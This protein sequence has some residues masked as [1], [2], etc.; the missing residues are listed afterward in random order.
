[1][2]GADVGRV[3]WTRLYWRVQKD[4]PYA[5]RPTSPTRLTAAP[6]LSRRLRRPDHKSSGHR[7]W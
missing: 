2:E 4:P 7:Q 1:M 5:T 3:L 6:D